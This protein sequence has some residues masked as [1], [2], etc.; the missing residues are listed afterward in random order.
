MKLAFIGLG[1]MGSAMA[2]NLV[3]AGH[4]VA[5][6]NRSRAKAEALGPGVRIAEAPEVAVR[7]CEAAITMLADDTAVEEIVWGESGI[8]RGL[9]SGSVHLGCSTIS[10]AL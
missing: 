3:E 2:G 4:E 10:T 1:N 7:N 8:T 9:P 6:Y 5:V